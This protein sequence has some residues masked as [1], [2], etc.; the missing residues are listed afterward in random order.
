[1]LG[2]TITKSIKPKTFQ[3]ED[4]IKKIISES[5]YTTNGEFLIVVKN[6]E[7][8][9]I[10]LD[11]STTDHIVIKAL[12]KV[13]VKHENLI[14]GYYHELVMDNGSS[15]ELCEVDGIYFIIASDGLKFE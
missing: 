14:D 10:T 6:V 12:T 13:I 3:S 9:T 2:K 11:I 8:S 5:E 7:S 1:M 15:V 4:K